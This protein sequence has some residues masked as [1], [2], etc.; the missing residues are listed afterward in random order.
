MAGWELGTK[1]GIILQQF[2]GFLTGL[3]AGGGGWGQPGLLLG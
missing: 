2:M 1:I 3:V